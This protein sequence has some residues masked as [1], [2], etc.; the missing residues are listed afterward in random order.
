MRITEI[1]ISAIKFAEGTVRA[2]AI[3]YSNQLIHV[4]EVAIRKKKETFCRR[5]VN[6]GVF[7]MNEIYLFNLILII[8]LHTYTQMMWCRFIIIQFDT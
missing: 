3:V 8:K 4:I 1:R 7:L 5:A 2:Y 6:N